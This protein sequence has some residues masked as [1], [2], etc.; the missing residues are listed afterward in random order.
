MVMEKLEKDCYHRSTPSTIT[1]QDNKAHS[2]KM[3]TVILTQ[4]ALLSP[5]SVADATISARLGQ[6]MRMS[7]SSLLLGSFRSG[8]KKNGKR[9]GI[10]TISDR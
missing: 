3:I 9:T 1:D 8:T 5:K 6:P 2:G 10:T 4:Q 7:R